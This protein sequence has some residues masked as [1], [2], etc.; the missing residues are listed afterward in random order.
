MTRSDDERESRSDMIRARATFHDWLPA[1]IALVVVSLIQELGLFGSDHGWKLFWSLIDLVPA[2]WI[3][4]AVVR[5]FSAP[6]SINVAASSRRWR[7][8]SV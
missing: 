3:V 6:M 7:S 1:L 8:D 4:R 2:L 5:A